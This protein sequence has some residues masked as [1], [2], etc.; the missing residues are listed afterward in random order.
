MVGRYALREMEINAVSLGLDP[1]NPHDTKLFITFDS[2]HLGVNTPL[3]L[4]AM[5][6]KGWGTLLKVRNIFPLIALT[7]Q[8]QSAKNV[9]R[10]LN[11]PAS[12]QMLTYSIAGK[13]KDLVHDNFIHDTFYD[14]YSTLGWP[15]LAGIRTAA[16]ASG[17]ECGTQQSFW[18]WRKAL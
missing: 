5:A 3:G 9:Y 14:K 8:Y 7:G 4:Q 17:A 11:E 12:K 6:S 16:V 1:A 2:P 10:L 18:A 15:Q 13:G